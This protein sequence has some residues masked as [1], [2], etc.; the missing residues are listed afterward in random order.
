M[1]VEAARHI[2]AMKTQVRGVRGRVQLQQHNVGLVVLSR[3]QRYTA[4]EAVNHSRS[5]GAATT[6][7]QPVNIPHA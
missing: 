5:T 4:V 6:Q 2:G 7:H 3:V 1:L